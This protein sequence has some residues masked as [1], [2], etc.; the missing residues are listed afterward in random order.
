[1]VDHEHESRDPDVGWLLRKVDEVTGA[2][3]HLTE[4][5]RH[6]E[7]VSVL[8]Q[9]MC[10]HVLQV[11]P[12]A[13]MASVSLVCDGSADTVAMTDDHAVEIDTAQY[14]SGEGP[15]LESAKTG[16]VVR[17]TVPDIRDKW[18]AFVDAAGKAAVA[19]YLSAPLFI[20]SEYHGSLNLYGEEPHGFD[21][22]DAA[23]LELYTTAA[24]AALRTARRSL[25]A[26]ELVE[27]VCRALVSRAVIDQAKGIIMATRR[28]AAD[29]AFTLLVE[30]AQKQNVDVR[31]LAQRLVDDIL[32]ND[33]E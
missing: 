31:D 28:V 33:D 25:Q 2:L 19:S 21:E 24:E 11:I 10:Q 9:G 32:E 14:T 18:P 5:L 23:L 20:D 29:E 26:R 6:E 22:L 12:Q 8:L 15:C 17:V 30:Q 1:M 27:N 4:A 7:N 3:E 16:Q 13:D